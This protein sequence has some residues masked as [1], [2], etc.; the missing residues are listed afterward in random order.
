[1]TKVTIGKTRYT[2]QIVD[3]FPRSTRTG[4]IDFDEKTI[5]L[6]RY[7]AISGRKLSDH[8]MAGV[9]W[10]EAMHAILKDMNNMLA[11]NEKFVEGVSSRLAKLLKQVY[12]D[13]PELVTHRAEGL[14]ELRPKVL[15]GP[16]AKK[17][18]VH[19]DGQDAVRRP[20]A[21]SRRGVRQEG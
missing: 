3:K 16:G 15:R 12:H 17:A 21:Q 13:E 19:E 5:K 1:M 2:V 20:T 8:E 4:E 18:S 10:H 7:G 6:A 9:F 11:H 14:R